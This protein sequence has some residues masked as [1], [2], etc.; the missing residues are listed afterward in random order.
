MRNRVLMVLALT[1]GW[2]VAAEECRL[3]AHRGGSLEF[4]E[5][6]LGAFQGR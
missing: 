6:T 5:N 4:E 3:V 2:V 1:A